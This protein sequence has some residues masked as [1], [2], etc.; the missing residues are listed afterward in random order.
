VSVYFKVR[1]RGN[2]MSFTKIALAAAVF[3]ITTAANA[4]ITQGLVGYWNFDDCTAKDASGNAYNGTIQGSPSCEAGVV[5]KALKFNTAATTDWIDLGNNF[6]APKQFTL[7]A[8]VNIVNLPNNAWCNEGTIFA[9]GS[10]CTNNQISYYMAI[11]GSYNPM[12]IRQDI[13]DGSGAYVSVSTSRSA[14]LHPPKTNQ[15]I[16]LVST[17]DGKTLSIYGNH[18]YP[19]RQRIGSSNWQI[20]VR[21]YAHSVY[22]SFG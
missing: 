9:K 18:Y 11:E 19:S 7:S 10:A 6:P 22:G 15:W 8:W 13:G 16:H 21:F 2:V 1:Q 4:D 14:N 17:Y 12:F 3:T 20:P 5:G